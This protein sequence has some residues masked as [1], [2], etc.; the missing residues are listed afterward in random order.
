MSLQHEIKKRQP[1]EVLEQEVCLNMRRTNDLL[2]LE[3]ERLFREY[4]LTGQQYNV[5][6]ILRGAGGEGL[7]SQEVAARMIGCVPDM[8][9]LIDRLLAAGLV[10]RHRIETDRRVVLVRIS[11]AGLKLLARLDKPVVELHKQQLGHLTRKELQELN[12]LLLKA[13]ARDGTPAQHM[14][15]T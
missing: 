14:K 1:F 3:F 7:P 12:R 10:E 2:G 11:P 4:E 15:T 5:L 6:R 9:R 13:R 8:T